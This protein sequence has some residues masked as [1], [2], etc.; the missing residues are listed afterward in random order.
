MKIPKH[1]IRFNGKCSLVSYMRGTEAGGESLG[2]L[3]AR[4]S[5][6]IRAWRW[7]RRRRVFFSF[8]IDSSRRVE[9]RRWGGSSMSVVVV[10]SSA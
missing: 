10:H 9:E 4:A 3:N 7:G 2:V 8:S 1:S 5:F 6:T